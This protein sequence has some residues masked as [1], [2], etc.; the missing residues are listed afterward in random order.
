MFRHMH[1]PLNEGQ[2]RV[3][4]IPT[5]VIWEMRVI[6]IAVL[7]SSRFPLP[8]DIL[9]PSFIRH[10]ILFIFSRSW[11]GCSVTPPRDDIK[12]DKE[13]EQADCAFLVVSVNINWGGGG[14][15]GGGG[16]GG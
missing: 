9:L 4:G 7:E 11:T 12:P 8:R 2:F 13:S 10:S 15:M 1:V 14:G 6:T 3:E 5:R 16:G